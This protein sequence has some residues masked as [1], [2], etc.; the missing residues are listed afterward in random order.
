MRPTAP[1]DYLAGYPFALIEPVRR[2]LAD[3]TLG[4]VL[5][6]RYPRMHA[7]RTDKAL[8][9]YVQEYRNEFLRN[10]PPLSKVAF[11]G[12]IR[13]VGQVLGTH[14]R[15]ARVQGAKL[16]S[17]NEI[18]IA[19]VFREMPEE[20]LRMIV[21]HELAHLRIRDHDKEFYRLCQYMEP[22]YHQLE[23]DARVWLLWLDAQQNGR[24]D[25]GAPAATGQ[26]S[27]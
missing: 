1:P 23:F 21:V 13:V 12:K 14:T 16:K 22:A 18:R 4:S 5:R 10:S 17:K 15:I 26:G 27:D 19:A 9:D 2:R 25:G 7:V 3:G 11:D 20:L 24:S 6:Q 8:Y